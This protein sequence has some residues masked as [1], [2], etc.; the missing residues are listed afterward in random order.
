VLG[1]TALIV[2][3]VSVHGTREKTYEEAIAEQKTRSMDL[4]GSKAPKKKNKPSQKEP[5]QNKKPKN[6]KQQ[7]QHNN[8]KTE[9]KKD[10]VVSTVTESA[11]VKTELEAE[12]EAQKKEEK[13]VQNEISGEM[14]QEV[15]KSN[16]EEFVETEEEEFNEII[17]AQEIKESFTHVN[18]NGDEDFHEVDGFQVCKLISQVK[19]FVV[20]VSSL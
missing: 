16:L 17:E 19:F 3:I 14:T 2:Y 15:V 4:M 18:G 1:F 11:K 8:N 5:N 7:V 6:K 10:Q 13:T 12:P 20:S 9:T